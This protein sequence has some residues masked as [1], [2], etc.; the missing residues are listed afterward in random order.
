MK[1]LRILV[2]SAALAIAVSPAFANEVQGVVD[3]VDRSSNTV[4][5]VDP[6]NG[7]RA[8]VRVH[9]KAAG[10]LTK[11][12]VVKARLKPGTQDADSLEVIVAR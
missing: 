1:N 6:A 11:G 9:P 3:S 5:I 10:D 7:N 12:A 2:L 8:D 4:T